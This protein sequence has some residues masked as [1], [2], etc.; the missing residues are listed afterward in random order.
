M[1]TQKYDEHFEKLYDEFIHKTDT[2]FLSDFNAEKLEAFLRNMSRKFYEQGK[3]QKIR[4]A[5]TF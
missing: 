1:K 4:S 3:V 5:R 2:E